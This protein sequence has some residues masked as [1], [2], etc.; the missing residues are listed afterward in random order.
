MSRRQNHESNFISDCTLIWMVWIKSFTIL[1]MGQTSYFTYLLISLILFYFKWIV[2]SVLLH[3]YLDVAFFLTGWNFSS[4]YFYLYWIHGIKNYTVYLLVY[5]I[6]RLMEFSQIHNLS[7]IS[8][9]KAETL[10]SLVCCLSTKF[11]LYRSS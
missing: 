6:F 10:L 4:L 8:N 3:H 5:F 7:V 1:T 9:P 11:S 2:S